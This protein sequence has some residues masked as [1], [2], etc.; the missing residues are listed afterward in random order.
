MASFYGRRP[1]RFMALLA[2]ALTTGCGVGAE[3][4]PDAPAKG[5]YVQS[6]ADRK[7]FAADAQRQAART[8]MFGGCVE[9]MKRTFANEGVSMPDTTIADVC[10]CMTDQRTRRLTT[11]QILAGEVGPDDGTCSRW[12][13]LD[14]GAPGAQG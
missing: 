13:G 3:R 1:M 4:A 10:G 14:G 9:G 5:R 8:I 7:L 2:Y 11:A 12:T 6:E